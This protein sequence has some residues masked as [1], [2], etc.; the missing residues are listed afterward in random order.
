MELVQKYRKYKKIELFLVDPVGRP[1]SRPVDTTVS[2][3]PKKKVDPQKWSTQNG[4]PK[5][6]LTQ[7]KQKEIE[8]RICIIYSSF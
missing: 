3:R 4:R 8:P 2:C 6:G 1:E 5:K 7:I